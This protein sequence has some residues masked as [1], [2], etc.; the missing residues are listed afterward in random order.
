[1]II[2]EGHSA[3]PVKALHKHA[4]RIEIRKSERSHNLRH[5]ALASELDYLVQQGTRDFDVINEVKPAETHLP[6][7]PGLICL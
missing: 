4:L 3:E 5:A 2:Y 7:L 1:M 6:Y